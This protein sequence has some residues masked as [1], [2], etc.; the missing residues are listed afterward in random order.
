[1]S[2]TPTPRLKRV[3]V[4]VAVVAA[5]V[6]GGWVIGTAIGDK[7]V[8]DRANDRAAQAKQRVE[9]QLAADAAE[10]RREREEARRE[11]EAEAPDEALDKVNEQLLRSA[12][13]GRRGDVARQEARI[14][15]LAR[16]QAAA[17]G[18]AEPTSKD[19]YERE[20]DRFPINQPP[21]VAQQITS[22]DDH[23]LFVSVYKSHFCLKSPR[24][25][26]QAV[27]ETY[28]PIARSLRREKIRDFEL[29]VVPV[30]Q[31]APRR[32][33]ALARAS[34]RTVSLTSRGQRC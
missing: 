5:A 30:G 31:N 11:H 32:S 9:R 8:N 22:S 28:E 1:V 33:Q 12:K 18:A 27:R 17:E 15:E 7:R 16:R 3:A 29:L 26:R 24:E 21:L 13:A 14:T 4:A 6:A 23:V 34:G 2:S 25:R 19:P 10:A 20:L